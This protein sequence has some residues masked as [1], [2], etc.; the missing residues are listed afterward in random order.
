MSTA[1]LLSSTA[2]GSG[3]DSGEDS[4]T[5][6]EYIEQGGDDDASEDDRHSEGAQGHYHRGKGRHYHR[7]DHDGFQS[8]VEDQSPVRKKKPRNSTGSTRRSTDS[9][10]RST[11]SQSSLSSHSKS[12][13]SGSGTYSDLSVPKKS[14]K[15][16]QGHAISCSPLPEALHQDHHS[17]R[18]ARRISHSS[19][20]SGT[21][22]SRS[23]SNMARGKGNKNTSGGPSRRNPPRG[24]QQGQQDQAAEVANEDP[25]ADDLDDDLPNDIP[26]LKA[27]IVK[28]GTTLQKWK[29]QIAELKTSREDIKAKYEQVL[30]DLELVR[31]KGTKKITDQ[32]KGLVG[33]AFKKEVWRRVKFTSDKTLK[34]HTKAVM[35][36]MDLDE[37]RLTGDQSK[38]A[39]K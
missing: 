15:A 39:G 27:I 1:L 16:K 13:R 10:R 33:T 9:T 20:R 8:A 32:M 35:E 5:D 12:S 25:P 38:D 17:K 22:H 14:K 19:S 23:S 18:E 36:V 34:T 11:E 28:N 29:K 31:K 26:R 21:S 2:A 30:A 24:G 3:T 37:L 6:V 4:G 7:E